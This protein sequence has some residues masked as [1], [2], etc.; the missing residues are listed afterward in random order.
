M[1]VKKI[2]AVALAAVA[3]VAAWADGPF[4]NHR[5]D[6]FK[7][8]PTE[9][10]QIV[11]AGNSITN[12]HSWFEAFGSN[13]EVVGR[14]NSG[15]F[16][17]ELLDN[18]ESYIDSK[19][20]KFFVMIGTNDISSGVSAQ[21]TAKRI[22]T[23]VNRVRLESPQTDVYVQ[24]ILPRSSNRK[25]DYEQCNDIVR[26]FV[27]NL[28]DPKVSFIN[29]SEVCAGLNGNSTW[30]HDGLHPRPIGYAA[31]THHIEPQV[32]YASVYPAEITS[33][34]GCG[35]TNSDAARAEQ[36][37]YYPVKQGDV[38]FFGDEQVHGAEWHELLRSDKIKDRGMKWGW[39]GISLPNARQVIASALENQAVKPAKIFLFYGVGGKVLDNYR[40]LIDE[41]KSQAPQAKVY[42][43][44]L[45]PS[46]NATTNA[47]NVS[48]NTSIASIAEEKGAT[49]VDIYTPLA[50]NVN[51]NIMGTNYVSGRGYIVMANEL[52]KHLAEEQVNP[53]S[54]EEYQA[55][56]DRRSA[57]AII[58]N[59]MTSAMMLDYG[60]QPGQIKESYRAQ[61]EEAIGKAAAEVNAADLTAESANAA[62]GELVS[63]VTAATL[64][65][66]LPAA[67]TDAE[68]HWY[69][70]TSSRNGKALTAA[71]SKLIGGDVPGA[72]T[73]GAN[74]WKF[75]ER[76]DDTY[77]VV[78]ANGEYVS[79][80]AAYNTQV[81]VTATRPDKGFSLS[82]SNAVAGTFVIYTSDCQLNQTTNSGLP[83]YNWY[84]KNGG[85]PD[86]NDNGCAYSLAAFD[87]DII[88]VD[89]APVVSGW[90]EIT[91]AAD[92][93]SVTNMEAPVRQTASNSYSMQYVATP[94]SS[95]KNW[96][97]ISVDG[98]NRQVQV[99]NG[100]YVSDF[101]TN[102]RTG[103]NLNM[104]P[105][106]TVAGAYNVQY[107]TNFNIAGVDN[108]IGRS[109]NVNSAHMFRRVQEQEMNSY[110]VWTVRIAANTAAE[111]MNDT[112]VTFQSEANKGI[113]TVYN[114]GTFFLEPGTVVNAADLTV[115]A[116]EGVEQERETPVITIDAARKVINVVLSGEIADPEEPATQTL[117]QGWYTLTLAAYEGTRTDLAGWVNTALTE[118]TTSLHATDTEYEQSL[119]GSKYYYHVGVSNPSALASPVLTYFQVENPT[120]TT[121]RLRSQ[122]GHHVMANG[123]AGRQPVDLTLSLTNH[124]NATLPICLWKGNN[125]GCN[126]HDLI[127]SFS[128]NSCKY[129]VAPAEL[130]AYDVYTV[131]IVGE[132]PATAVRDDVKVTLTTPANRGLQSVYNG[133]T[134]F[135]DK[136]A[137][138]NADMVSAP[139]HAGNATPVISIADGVIAVD[140]TK[141]QTAV[142]ELEAAAP[143]G[144]RVFDLW[145]RR[146]A[147][148]RH[149]LYI[150]NGRKVRI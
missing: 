43:V 41:A 39:G 13:Q 12:M 101:T 59:A 25:P 18:L 112:R 10:G 134:F 88:D 149:G 123:T 70:L 27:E 49:Y 76:G 2:C 14:G 57:R 79:P 75:I 40:L 99:L 148:P 109:S 138:V 144:D 29:L 108:V 51:A 16:A 56:Y 131:N 91:R 120:L 33:Q 141:V 84:S 142:A 145:G 26:E 117:A 127:G 81:S 21:L 133:G 37:P 78:N 136:G 147:T 121:M 100:F 71:D 107:W 111:V 58:G 102:S 7:A 87:G 83:V 115:T 93:L 104:T 32:G 126:D 3:S 34:N 95:P 80:L 94:Q 22:Q 113:A 96:V 130:E 67:S 68:S 92:N 44:S 11:F 146:V 31:W 128:G 114:G 6:S 46:S 69:V 20:S 82:Y 122:N 125:I 103:V 24:S 61:I 53:V 54:L 45:T 55:V 62:A 118:G 63:V 4:R 47:E 17:Y 8:T 23:I 105:S 9:Y 36:F 150:V 48:F 50:E 30:S 42:V 74:V 86:R 65:L 89:H 106:T 77:D 35:L 110:D 60:T 85:T 52:A 66:N 124:G 19:P 140:Y 72:S 135:V 73:L 143:K 38:L 139:E 28:N 119:N 132:T 137:E 64:D 116:P 15:G 97:Y 5:Y 1:N 129:A 98:E 90:Y